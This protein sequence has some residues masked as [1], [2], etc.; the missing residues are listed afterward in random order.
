MTSTLSFVALLVRRLA[1][2]GA[3]FLVIC[4]AATSSDARAAWTFS[5][6]AIALI[7]TVRAAAWPDAWLTGEGD[8]LGTAPV[9]RTW[10][11]A[12]AW[13]GAAL[14]TLVLTAAASATI[15]ARSAW[16]GEVGHTLLEAERIAGPARSIVLMPGESFEQPIGEPAAPASPGRKREVRVRSTVTLGG[17]T[18]TTIALIEAGG[19]SQ[20][21]FVARRTW[22]A[23][24]LPGAATSVRVTNVGEGALAILGPDP[25]EVWSSSNAWLGGVVRMWGH[26]SAWLVTLVSLALLLGVVMGPGVAAVLAACVWLGAWMIWSR[27]AGAPP[28]WLPGG[29]A[30]QRALEATHEQRSPLAPPTVAIAAAA[31]TVMG[32]AAVGAV[33]LRHWRDEV[34]G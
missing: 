15:A 9:P 22:L 7:A 14:G 3:L 1:T 2:P 31:A 12:S 5:V 32:G 16:D 19:A 23:V 28:D 13:I 20:R 18:P 26:A 33:L 29:P 24:D 17:E 8:W 11:M 30:F 10:L 25:V 21:I 6:A 34:R 4:V 27:A